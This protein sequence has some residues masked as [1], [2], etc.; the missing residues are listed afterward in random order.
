MFD[1]VKWRKELF[2]AFVQDD[3]FCYE[4]GWYWIEDE[5]WMS[6]KVHVNRLSIIISA[7]NLTV[8]QTALHFEVNFG[9]QSQQLE[10]KN[11]STKDGKSRENGA[12]PNQPKIDNFGYFFLPEN[13]MAMMTKT[14]STK[15]RKLR[16]IGRG[17]RRWWNWGIG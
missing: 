16:I 11:G 13:L 10:T 12:N 6:G 1:F 4:F 8:G 15:I 14:W 5:K 3:E 9:W 2:D 17:E 7:I